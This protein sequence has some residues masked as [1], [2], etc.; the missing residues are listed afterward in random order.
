V[1]ILL[2]TWY[3]PPSRTIAAVRLGKLARY[4]LS[5][6][7]DVRVLTPKEPPLPQDLSVDFPE[8]RV[9]RTAWRDPLA[10][11]ASGPRRP[12]PATVGS[13]PEGGVSNPSWLKRTLWRLHASFSDF[14]DGRVTWQ[15]FAVE[16]GGALL[17]GWQPDLVFASGP[18]FTTLFV[19]RDL[20]RRFDLPLVLEFRDRWSEDPYAPPFFW[21]RWRNRLAENELIA[22]ARA[23]VT[24]S[25]PWAKAYR[26]RYGKPTEVVYNGYDAEFCGEG[27][28]D[29]AAGRLALEIVYTGGIYPGYRDPSPLFAAMKLLDD[30]GL[31]CRMI[32]H[33]V[34]PATVTPLAEA[35]GVSHL[36]E[37]REVLAHEEALRRQRESDILV[38]LQWNDPKEQGN[39]PGKFFEYLGARRPILVLGL[40]DGVPATIVKEREAGFFSNDP[41]EIAGQ[42]TRWL[43]IK[44]EKGL[45][46]P[47]P[48]SGRAGFSRDEQYARLERFF[49]D[50]LDGADA[51]NEQ[52][53]A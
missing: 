12:P 16:A 30:R 6:G 53:R 10:D 18:P 47:V 28:F 3:F 29:G 51:P 7:H 31:Q 17:D 21:R 40:H 49:M 11:G 50:L 2:V 5:Q 43:E 34:R 41:E 20:S 48:E 24:V 52:R 13:V 15:P 38:L 36:V 26:A 23:L 9:T 46:P 44:R 14:P 32:F 37:I 1:K 42:L 39:V 4:L 35:Q 19:G 8:E 45:L 25:A 27:P 22:Q 33:G